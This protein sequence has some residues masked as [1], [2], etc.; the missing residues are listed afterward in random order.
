MRGRG[1]IV[2]LQFGDYANHVGAHF[3]NAQ[4]EG[5]EE[6]SSGG[7]IDAG[8]LSIRDWLLATSIRTV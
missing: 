3:W 1:E 4:D 2:T 7:E 5:L 8:V 6:A